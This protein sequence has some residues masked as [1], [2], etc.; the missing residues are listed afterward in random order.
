M[1][2]IVPELTRRHLEEARSFY[3]RIPVEM[4]PAS[5]RYRAMLAHY[6][7]RLISADSSVLEVGCGSGELL[8]RIR[9]GSKVGID[10]SEK[11]I[12]LAKELVPD[13]QFQVAAGEFL[14][15]EGV[16]DVIILSDTL[17]FA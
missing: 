8:S 10:L 15:L 5:R 16:F 1:P 14:E 12:A 11:R 17:N 9:A 4:T 3:D 7:S 13:A 6:Y 2:E